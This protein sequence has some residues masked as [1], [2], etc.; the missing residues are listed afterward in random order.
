VLDT[1]E[2]AEPVT[3][4]MSLNAPNMRWWV[5][6]DVA[7]AGGADIALCAR[8]LHDVGDEDEQKHAMSGSSMYLQ[9]KTHPNPMQTC[10]SMKNSG[11]GDKPVEGRFISE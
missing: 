5:G 3:T 1:E 8:A 10:V 7:S 4:V 9:R 2:D 6:C 11:L